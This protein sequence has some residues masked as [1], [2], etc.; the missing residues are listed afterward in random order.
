MQIDVHTRAMSIPQ[1]GYKVLKASP[2]P[3]DGPHSDDIEPPTRR[4]LEPLDGDS[5]RRTSDA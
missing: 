2:K 5:T 3:V 1:E 4:V